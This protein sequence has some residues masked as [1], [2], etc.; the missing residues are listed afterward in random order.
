MK[1]SDSQ[2]RLHV[3]VRDD[4]FCVA[5]QTDV[6]QSPLPTVCITTGCCKVFVESQT[7]RILIKTAEDRRHP[8]S[9]NF[10]SYQQEKLSV[11]ESAEQTPVLGAV[12]VW[13][14]GRGHKWVQWPWSHAGLPRWRPWCCAHKPSRRGSR[15]RSAVAAAVHHRT[16]V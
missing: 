12:V 8:K 1:R 3:Q 15:R 5:L 7:R 4:D 16:G 6:E 9:K 14:R 13:L 11:E 10:L 2:R